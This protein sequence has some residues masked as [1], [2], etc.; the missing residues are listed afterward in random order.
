MG[1]LISHDITL[2]SDSIIYSKVHKRGLLTKLE[3]LGITHYL[4]SNSMASYYT[5]GLLILWSFKKVDLD[6]HR[7]PLPRQK[8][9]KSTFFYAF[10]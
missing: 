7:G 2:P 1:T 9:E 3:S 4:I 8:L 6:P 10:P 5:F